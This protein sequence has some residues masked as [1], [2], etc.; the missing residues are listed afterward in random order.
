MKKIRI[1]QI[2][3]L[4]VGLFCY[5][6]CGDDEPCDAHIAT[7]DG[8]VKAIINNSCTTS[9]CHSGADGNPNLE[10]DAID[11]TNF[12]GMDRVLSDSAFIKQVLIEKTMPVGSPLEA[13]QIEILTCWKD[14]GFPEN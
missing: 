5:A 3:F 6:S 10:A 14:A 11:F 7:Y 2:L 8:D 1:I 9:N 4:A 12:A 13:E